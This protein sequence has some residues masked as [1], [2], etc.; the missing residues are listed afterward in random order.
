MADGAGP[1]AGRGT[2]ALAVS[3]QRP[4]ASTGASVSAAGDSAVI[5][6]DSDTIVVHSVDI[7]VRRIELKPVEVAG[8]ESDSSAMEHGDDSMAHEDSVAA[9][10]REGCEEIKA[11]PVLVSLPLGATAIEALVNVTA[12]AGQYNRLEFRIHA[13]ELPRDS[14]FLTANPDFAGVSIRVV[15]TFRHAGGTAS[16]FTYESGLEAEQEVAIDPPLAVGA[17]SVASVTLRFDISEWFARFGGSGLVDPGTANVGGPNA[18]LV[19]ENIQ[20]SINAFE[21]RNRDGHDDGGGD[22]D[23]PGGGTRGG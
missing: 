6:S 2:V 14:A 20:R 22:G 1:G 18:G 23:G 17:D 4:L 5:A 13:P 19:G 16:A 9:R 8:C 21:D 10:D 7:V 3:A 12:P 15:G 11:G